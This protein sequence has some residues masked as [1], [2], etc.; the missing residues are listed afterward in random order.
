MEIIPEELLDK[1]SGGSATY[2]TVDENN[3]CPKCG[4]PMTLFYTMRVS[5]VDRYLTYKCS[6]CNSYYTHDLEN[7]TWEVVPV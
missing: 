2:V 4:A 1:I 3:N 7:D 6:T 5:S